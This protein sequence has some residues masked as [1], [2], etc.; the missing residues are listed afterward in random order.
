MFEGV[1][2]S[3]KTTQLRRLAT[4]L[5]GSGHRVVET[6]EPG[7]CVVGERIRDILLDPATLGLSAEGEMLLFAAARAE[8]VRTTI[9]PAV[10]RGDIVLCD[11]FVGS[12]LAYQGEGRGLGRDHV[13]ASNVHA[14]DGQWP[15]LCI[16]LD[17]AETVAAA[18]ARARGHLDRIEAESAAFHMRVA[19]GFHAEA[20]RRELNVVRIDAA[21]AEDLI[22]LRIREIVAPLVAW[23]P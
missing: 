8:H 13:W 9:R 17:L 12:S 20:Q 3:G 1:E 14:V 22:E 5:R 7:G 21:G 10:E 4:F 2:G 15:D 19:A 23:A 18:R 16:W 6:R 11:R